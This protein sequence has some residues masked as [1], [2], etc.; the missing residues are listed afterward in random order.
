MFGSADISGEVVAIFA[1]AIAFGSTTG[2]TIW[3]AIENLDP[4]QEEASLAMGYTRTKVFRK[5]IFPQALRACMPHLM[6]QFVNLIRGT[7]VVGYIAVVDL[8]RASDMIRSRT[9]DAFFPL[10]STALIYF[11]LCRIVTWPLEKIATFRTNTTNKTRAVEEVVSRALERL[12][13]PPRRSAE[14]DHGISEPRFAISQAY[15]RKTLRWNPW[16]CRHDKREG[17]RASVATP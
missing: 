16:I 9:M 15:N 1:F 8:T 17:L 13:R 11:V 10:V 6:S 4:L 3:T 7:S 5:I 2:S 12:H 14:K